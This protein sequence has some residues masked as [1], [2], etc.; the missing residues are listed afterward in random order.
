MTTGAAVVF[1]AITS[2]VVLFQLALA[3]GAPW[4]EYA[5]GGGSP[6]RFPPAMRVAAV[7]QALLLALVAVVVLA[8]ARLILPWLASTLPWLIWLVVAFAAVS[9]VLNTLT[10]SAPERRLWV[11]VTLAMLVTSLIVALSQ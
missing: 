7:A 5:M 4:G 2:G 1:A 10:P 8:D 6:G 3:L 11:P 9:V